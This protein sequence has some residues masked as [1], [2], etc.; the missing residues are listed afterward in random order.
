MRSPSVRL[1]RI[2]GR[3]AGAIIGITAAALTAL[4]GAL[5]P[6]T[7][8]AQTQICSSQTGTESGYYYSLWENGTGSACL[9][10]NG[11]AYSTSWSSIGDFTAGVGW[12]PGNTNT[13]NFTSSVSDSGGTALV[14]VYGWMTNPLV[15]YYVE[16]NW[17]GSTN[18]TGTDL[19]TF[20]DGSSTYTLWEH[21]QVNQPSIDGTQTFEQ[22]IAVRSS[23]TSSASVNMANVEAAWEAKGLPVGT[24]NY[25]I[26]G[27]E[28]Y[29]GGTGSTSINGGASTG[30]G[31][32]GSGGGSGSCTATL[33]ADGQGSNYYVL[34]VAVSGSSSWTVT[35]DMVA[36]AVVYAVNGANATYPSEYVA[37]LTPGSGG[38]NFTVTVSPNGQWT[39]P[40]VSCAT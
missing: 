39:W 18:G 40:S 38:N 23:P 33:S 34:S 26:V 27:S 12:N 24:M 2:R 20:T 19:G 15:E 31:G 6:G 28:A 14:S 17:S 35:L 25:E 10:Y 3:F 7:A 30:G 8:H 21:Q 29:G 13:V 16:E 11:S 37:K 4:S 1:P 22:Y 32:G 9:T 5:L 36:P